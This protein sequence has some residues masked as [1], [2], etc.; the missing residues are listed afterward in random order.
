MIS[1][2]TALTYDTAKTYD[3]HGALNTGTGVF[4]AP[5]SGYYDVS[6][7]IQLNSAAGWGLGEYVL[8]SVLKNGVS[9]ALGSYLPA[10]A[11]N[12]QSSMSNGSCGV[13]LKKNDILSIDVFQNNGA[14]IA[15][16]TSDFANFFSIHKTS[17]GTGN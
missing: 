14:T 15:L 11:A 7:R 8:A 17:V 3:T 16:N 9:F 6:W 13:Y 1:G 4:T 12:S 10:Q 5:E 2:T